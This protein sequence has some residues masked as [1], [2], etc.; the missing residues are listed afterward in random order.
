[1]K[2]LM[3]AAVMI[4]STSAAFA[5]DSETLKSILKAKTYA[6][7]QTLINSNL[8]SLANDEERAKAYN[9]LVDLALEKVN[10]EQTV[11]LENQAA[12]QMG[13]AGDK[14]YDEEGL[15]QAVNNAMMAAFECNKFDQLPNAKG[16]VAPKFASKNADRLYVLRGQLINGGIFYQNKNDNDKAYK[17]LADYVETA[18]C[19]L[20]AKFNKNDDANLANIAYYATIYAYQA[21][22]W[23]KAE[24]YV[25]YAMKDPEKGKDAQSM[26]FAILGAQLETHADSLAYAQKLEDMYA[27]DPNNDDILSFLTIIYSQIN[28]E[29]AAMALLDKKL[30]ADPDNYAAANIKGQLLK[31]KEDY[32]N[33]IPLL[34]KS[35]AKAPN[36]DVKCTLNAAIGECYFF[37]AQERVNNYKGVLS[38]AAREQF[39]VVYNKA[40]EYLEEAKNLDITGANKRLYA[41]PL[42]GAYYFVKGAEASETK[43]AAADAGVTQ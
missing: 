40:I 43:A 36:D 20:F 28:K 39:N 5:G 37:K 22:D 14:P 21:K 19:P 15:Y 30:A 32:D 6:E 11:Q 4:L 29:D 18:D 41:Y 25:E 27:Q 10:K 31:Q 26:K 1:M 34:E 13:Q 35:L 8:S 42:Y 23:K 7:A 3:I 17:Y 12:Q 2:K 38:P 16:K 33:A 24:K 9:K